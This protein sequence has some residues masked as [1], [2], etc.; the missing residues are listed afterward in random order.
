MGLPQALVC[1]SFALESTVP[2][3]ASCNLHPHDDK[4]YSIKWWLV[5]CRGALWRD[6]LCL[7]TDISHKC[8]KRMILFY[9]EI[10]SKAIISKIIMRVC[11]CVKEERLAYECVV[12][13]LAYECVL[14]NTTENIEI[15]FS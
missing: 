8:V 5:C 4:R 10:I 12:K 9:S 1:N 14:Y 7:M 2:A 6:R 3:H 13:R 15:L 11:V